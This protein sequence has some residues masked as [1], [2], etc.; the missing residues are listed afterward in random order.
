MFRWSADQMNFSKQ[1]G[2][3]AM[4]RLSEFLMY[5]SSTSRIRIRIRIRNEGQGRIRIRKKKIISDPQHCPWI[6]K[7]HGSWKSQRPAVSFLCLI[8]GARFDPVSPIS[9]NYFL[10]GALSNGP[11]KSLYFTRQ[12]LW[13][14]KISAPLTFELH[15][16]WKSQCPA[17]FFSVSVCVWRRFWRNSLS[18]KEY[19]F[20]DR[21]YL[22]TI[23]TSCHFL[24]VW[25]FL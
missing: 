4:F 6:L 21:I 7:F 12:I 24:D 25:T 18:Q 8:S 19:F 13:R 23:T 2:F 1:S 16:P 10:F 22:E 3:F 20:F 15:R 11:H 14:K 5:F 17:V 9:N